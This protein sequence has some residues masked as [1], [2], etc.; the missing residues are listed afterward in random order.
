M[1]SLGCTKTISSKPSDK[2]IVEIQT[3]IEKITHEVPS[4][5]MM[6]CKPLPELKEN[7]Q[8]ARVRFVTSLI[9]VSKECRLIN[10]AKLDFLKALE[11]HNNVN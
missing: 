4:E 1:M 5:L 7:T 11:N 6:E 8:E 3:K 10:E 9:E 2:Q